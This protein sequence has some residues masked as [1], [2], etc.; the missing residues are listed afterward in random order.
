MIKTKKDIPITTFEKI[1]QVLCGMVILYI[2]LLIALR[3]VELPDTIPTHYNAM[4]EVD[5]WGSKSTILILYAVSLLMYTGLTVL[6]RFPQMY[7][8]PVQVTEK[9]IKMQYLLARSLI[10]ILKLGTTI[11]FMLIIVSGFRDQTENTSIILGNYFILFV[12]GITF[13]PI[14]VY[15]V[16]SYKH[17]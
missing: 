14:I 16:L 10:T 5:R 7:N 9:N 2:S 15:F 4:G 1:L 11:I 13:V 6:E 8:Y 12:L 17:R 3:Y